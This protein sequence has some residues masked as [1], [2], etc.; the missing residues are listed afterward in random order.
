M[1]TSFIAVTAPEREDGIG[2][3][4]TVLERG[5]L[6]AVRLAGGVPLV[7]SAA[8]EPNM[9][10]RMFQ[11][12]GGLL[13]TGGEDVD[14]ARYGE[15]P[16]GARRFSPSRDAMEIDLVHRA[17]ETGVPILA[18]CRGVQL[19]NVALGGTLYQDLALHW[20]D[21]IDHDR[22]REFGGSVHAIRP[23]GALQLRGVL[24]KAEFDQ[25]SA[26][27]QGIKDLAPGLHAAAY[28]PDGLV[29]AVELREHGAA[30][31][32]GVQWHPER[33]LEDASGTNRRLFERFGEEIG[34]S[35]AGTYS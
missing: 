7:M 13:L 14:P 25:N 5:Y 18:I 27:H 2:M 21:A 1:G 15:T 34:L 17:L 8:V 11:L 3:P 9:R 10:D 35:D 22:Y 33:K 26:H 23:D 4:G 19:L 31:T 12:A 16:M 32:V 28:A 6:E 30:W 29:E 20:S 24:A